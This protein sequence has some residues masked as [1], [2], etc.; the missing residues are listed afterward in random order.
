MAG[1]V[2][3]ETIDNNQNEPFKENEYRANICKTEAFRKAWP[4]VERLLDQTSYKK[5]VAIT[6]Q[7]YEK[8][9]N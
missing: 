5:K 4:L 3:Y 9:N 2:Y 7:H 6:V 1:Q 8:A